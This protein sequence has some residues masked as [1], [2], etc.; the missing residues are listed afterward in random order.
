[1]KKLI[2]LLIPFLFGCKPLCVMSQ[3]PPQNVI[4]G[5]NC[6]ALLPDYTNMVNVK[7]GCTGYTL[8]Q[9]PEPGTILT[10]SN[11]SIQVTLKAQGGNG[12]SSQVTFWVNLI[13]T[14]TPKIEP[15]AELLGYQIKQ[16]NDIYD[17]ADRM[18][19]QMSNTFEKNFP[20]KELGIKPDSI[21]FDKKLLVIVSMD[22]AGTRKRMATYL[23]DT[24]KQQF[25]QSK[26]YIP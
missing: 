1:M 20:Y 18:Q 7:S 15:V 17:V 24:L 22:S 6:V 19:I 2:L 3:I 9:T 25:Y 10:A 14:I 12:K 16:V 8:Y 26:N 13:D 4:A 5:S 11:K 21:P 23:N